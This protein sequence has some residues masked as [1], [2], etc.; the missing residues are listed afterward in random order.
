M[1]T[2]KELIE[3]LRKRYTSAN[4][5][6]KS[7]IIDEFEELSGFH[8]KHV[9]R[10]MNEKGNMQVSKPK[11]SKRI[12][13]DAVKEAL[14]ILWETSDRMCGKRLKAILPLLIESMERHGHL[15]L[16]ET[17]KEKLIDIS[18]STIDR[19][20]IPV[21]TKSKGK[22]RKKRRQR[23]AAK[24]IEIRTFADWN[25]PPPG[26]FEVDFV[27]HHGGS[28]AGS[29]VHTLVLTDIATAW[30]VCIP[31]LYREQT[32]VRKALDILRME[33][34]MQLR[35][36]DTDN[37]GAFINETLVDYCFDNGIEF[38]RSRPYRKNDQA[39]IEQKN[40]AVIRRMVGHARFQG[41]NAVQALTDLYQV[42]IAHVNFFEPSF[43]LISKIR[44]GSKTIKKY[45]TPMTP[46]DRLLAGDD[47][48]D[49][50]KEQLRKTRLQLDPARLI[51]NM[52]KAQSHLAELTA[53]TTKDSSTVN[54]SIEQFM[55]QLPQLWKAGE[56]RPTHRKPDKPQRHWRT[57]E[58]PFADVQLTLERWLE[59]DLDITAKTLLERLC[60]L[61]PEKYS[62]SQLRTLQ[63]RVKEWRQKRVEALIFQSN[64]NLNETLQIH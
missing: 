40:G 18:P 63:R 4:R 32:L 62:H 54:Q 47:I 59:E 64:Q 33:M 12:Y 5:K 15:N 30:T 19:M 60:A 16:D 13:D 6:M 25:N 34:P 2:Q 21:R 53:V 44:Q 27:A 45:D 38:T 28:M 10:L 50:V 8:R 37:D 1:A 52:R 39:W 31:L 26:F 51:Q 3:A 57:R 22:Q 17:V 24:Q 49:K 41:V 56:V 14:T 11:D 29:F 61:E 55:D 23:A 35:G 46:C 42:G 7:R 58:D 36:I 43:K 48:S 20:L 9:I